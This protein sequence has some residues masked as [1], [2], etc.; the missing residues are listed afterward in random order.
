M[1][2]ELPEA[3]ILAGQMGEVLPGKGVA[4]YDFRDIVYASYETIIAG[5]L[6]VLLGLAVV[7]FRK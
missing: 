2:A 5:L 1:S 7:Y 4:S 3:V 6:L